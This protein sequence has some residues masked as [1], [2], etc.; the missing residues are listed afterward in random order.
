MEYII[1]SFPVKLCHNIRTGR[2]RLFWEEKYRGYNASKREYFYGVKIE[3]VTTADGI[4]RGCPLSKV[5]STTRRS[6]KGC[7]TLPHF[8]GKYEFIASNCSSVGSI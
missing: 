6:S 8:M 3:L 2:C 4:R 1:D 5:P 7:M